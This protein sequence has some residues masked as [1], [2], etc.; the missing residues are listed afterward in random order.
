MY[1]L[2]GRL[3]CKDS[4]YLFS[5]LYYSLFVP[6]TLF[7]T[8]PTYCYS[9]S[10]VVNSRTRYDQIFKF[11]IIFKLLYVQIFAQRKSKN[12]KKLIIYIFYWHIFMKWFM[13]LWNLWAV[14]I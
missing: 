4:C 7:Q 6:A 3:E 2:L 10:R 5:N 8:Y 1:V 12:S 14:M 9:K 11:R 13:F